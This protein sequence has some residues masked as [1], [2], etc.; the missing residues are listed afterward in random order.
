MII[1]NQIDDSK[2]ISSRPWAHTQEKIQTPTE[3]PP[4]QVLTKYLEPQKNFQ[5]PRCTPNGYSKPRDIGYKSS[6]CKE[7]TNTNVKATATL[8]DNPKEINPR[9]PSL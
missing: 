4:P 8:Q 2:K 7:S 9:L 1:L 6:T 3:K 5:G